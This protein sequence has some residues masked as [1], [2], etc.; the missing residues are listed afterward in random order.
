MIKSVSK[1][2][3]ILGVVIAASFFSCEK[4]NSYDKG[5]VLFCTN[6]YIIN[7]P[8][9][10]DVYINNDCIGTLTAASS[11]SQVDCCCPDSLFIGLIIEKKVGIYSYLAK[12]TNCAGSNK[13]NNWTGEFELKKDGCTMILLDIFKQ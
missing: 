6:S 7:C 11:Y 3:L 2:L 12:E 5:E 9:S 1:I 4:D 13:V 10:I 8:F